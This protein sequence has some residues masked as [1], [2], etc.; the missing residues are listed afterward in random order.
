MRQIDLDDLPPKVAALFNHL[1]E[2][3]EIVIVQHGGVVA[4]LKVSEGPPP[5]AP[6][7]TLE[8]MPENERMAEVMAQFRATIEDEF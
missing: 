5:P 3:E 4:R 1:P 2:D 6:E 8:D 7:E